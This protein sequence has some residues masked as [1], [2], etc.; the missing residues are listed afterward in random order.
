MKFFYSIQTALKNT[1]YIDY[2]FKNFFFFIY[3]RVI[4]SNM[5]YLVDKY[6]AE[7]FFFNI[8]KVSNWLSIINST[9]AKMTITTIIKI[10]AVV[11]IQMLIIIFI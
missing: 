11:F 9:I 7:K 1:F 6:L 8:K 2:F 5:F 10:L 4:L 3:K